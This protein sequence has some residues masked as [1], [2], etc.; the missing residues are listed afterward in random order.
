MN[1]DTCCLGL[2]VA[3]HLSLDIPLTLFA[4][5]TGVMTLF[6]LWPDEV[7]AESEDGA[8]VS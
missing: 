3:F 1:V 2:W 5:L 7:E 8:C 4:V 6:K